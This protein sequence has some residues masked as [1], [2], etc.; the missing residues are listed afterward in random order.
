MR[1]RT[2]R[3]EI[4][5]TMIEKDLT[6]D[7]IS[8]PYTTDILVLDNCCRSSPVH[9]RISGSIPGLYPLHITRRFHS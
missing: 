5:E 4:K 6:Q 1:G 9:W 2:S 3:V 7:R 8:Q